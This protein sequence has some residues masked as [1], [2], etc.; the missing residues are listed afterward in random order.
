M[1]GSSAKQLIPLFRTEAT[2]VPKLV[3][4]E[5]WG[6][7]GSGT[8]MPGG[9]ASSQVH[10]G[11]RETAKR[12]RNLL[13]K[14]SQTSFILGVARRALESWPHPRIC[15]CLR[16]P[17]CLPNLLR[18]RGGAP[19]V[20]TQAVAAPQVGLRSRP[21]TSL[22]VPSRNVDQGLVS[23]LGELPFSLQVPRCVL[24]QKT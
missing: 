21:L 18:A 20:S 17:L 13:G 12:Q 16:L 4:Q 24:L 7:G 11:F 3:P 14:K 19:S 1:L 6:G 5:E 2:A 8:V 22:H 10:S 23:I 15:S 9:S